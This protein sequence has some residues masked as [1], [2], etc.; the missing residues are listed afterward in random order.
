MRILLNELYHGNLYPDEEVIP[1]DPHYRLVSRKT[2]EAIEAWKV[3]H[4][5]KEFNELEELLDL[6]NQTH[7]I[8]LASTFT[9]GFRLGAGIMVEVLTGQDELTHKLNN[10]PD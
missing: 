4:S 10:F 9:H 8:Q 6:Y 7:G 3:R 2:S 5:E 1:N